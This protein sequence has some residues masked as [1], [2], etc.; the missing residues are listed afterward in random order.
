MKSIVVLL[1]LLMGAGCKEA[2]EEAQLSSLSGKNY[3]FGDFGALEDYLNPK[4]SLISDIM[5]GEDSSY[6]VVVFDNKDVVV[7][8]YSS[9]GYKTT[10]PY[11]GGNLFIYNKTKNSLQTFTDLLLRRAA[12]VK[13]FG[14]KVYMAVEHTTKTY[15]MVVGIFDI[16]ADLLATSADATNGQQ[17]FEK[18]LDFYKLG[19]HVIFMAHHEKAYDYYNLFKFGGE[20]V[21]QLTHSTVVNTRAT[22][23]IIDDVAYMG[24]SD[25]ADNGIWKLDAD[26]LKQ[27]FLKG[28]DGSFHSSG[29]DPKDVRLGYWSG[30]LF[31]GTDS[32]GAAFRNAINSATVATIPHDSDPYFLNGSEFVIDSTFLKIVG[33]KAYLIDKRNT[34]GN[35]VLLDS[36]FNGSLIATD[37]N[38]FS[39]G[40]GLLYF[41]LDPH[42]SYES[43][44]L[45][46]EEEEIEF[47]HELEDTTACP[48][49]FASQ[50]GDRTF[51]NKN[52]VVNYAKASGQLC[53]YHD[54]DVREF[55]KYGFTGALE[56]D[57]LYANFNK[58]V[59]KIVKVIS[60]TEQQTFIVEY[61]HNARSLN[62]VHDTS[63]KISLISVGSLAF[64]CEEEDFNGEIIGMLGAYDLVTKNDLKLS[65][66]DT[67]SCDPDSIYYS[68]SGNSLFV[69]GD[70]SNDIG[71]ELYEVKF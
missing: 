8:F 42:T 2:L 56:V 19:S 13:P 44:R 45:I 67:G 32:L 3:D 31:F 47:S 59:M 60:E 28:V 17:S 7:G 61:D 14:S 15:P 30:N 48:K 38:P 37:I 53:L 25:G 39:K 1:I 12:L 26:D 40:P 69:G 54:H 68:P 50:A 33:D 63:N 58:T 27:E 4:L 52:V 34:S 21:T 51:Y 65:E 22:P 57:V 23:M 62:F 71:Y 35:L 55:S 29:G 64:F 24:Y 43:L 46:T 41:N 9:S 11:D 16:D 10:T 70:F 36:N 5:A 6:P 20:T 49:G 18:I 66:E